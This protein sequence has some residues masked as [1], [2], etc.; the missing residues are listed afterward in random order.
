[1]STRTERDSI[2]P[3]EVPSNKYFG[4]QTQRSYENF[5]IGSERFPREFI[6]AYGIIKKAASTVNFKFG[7]LDSRI[8]DSIHKA[9]EEVIDG[10]LDDHFP[11]VV[12][13]TGSGTQT[14]M[15]FNEVI[16]NRAIEIMGGKLGS[17]IPVHPNDHVNMSQST[18]DTF[19]TAINISAVETIH[20]QLLPEL[21]SLRD[22]L[23]KKSIE[24][25]SIIKL[26][27]THLQDA[28]PLSLGQEFS[29]YVSAIDHGISRLE[30]SLVHCYE[31]A[32]GGTA[33]GTGINSV[34]G[35]AENV[36][37]EISKL[38][39]FPFITAQNKFEALAGQDSIVE[40]SGT[41]K[42]IAGSLF[43]IANDLRWLA[44][45]PRSGIGEISLPAN[46]P[47]SSIMPG[48]INPTQCEAMTML[49]TQVMGN[50]V[51]ISIAGASGNFELNVYRPV[52]AFN[53]LQSLKLISDGCKSFTKNA[54]SGIKPNHDRINH[55]LYNSLMLVTALNPHIGYDKAAQVAKKAFNDKS[56]LREAVIE[57]GFLSAEQFDKYVNP[58]EMIYPKKLDS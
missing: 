7:N 16:S 5:E 23:N 38:T 17:K 28:T 41:L 37:I 54:V 10:K 6:R 24:F 2:G 34:D 8:K 15:N 29:G 53:I 22:A 1:M 35:F 33:V 26:G 12:W 45:G 49:C 20:N 47:G 27:R 46:E 13:Q 21:R 43:K 40:L 52:I 4:A 51:T 19:P 48:K 50:D 57:L 30:S 14:N 3:I 39:G 36:A 44:S 25:K 58:G 32:M 18:N 56:S 55:N 9:S 11:L 31:L 42:V